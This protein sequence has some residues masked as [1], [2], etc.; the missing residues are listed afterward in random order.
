MKVICGEFIGR[1]LFS[2]K[3][4][5]LR[6]TSEKIR[7]AI[8]DI[9]LHSIGEPKI[10]GAKVLDLFCGTGA[11]GI[12]ALSRGAAHA[13]FVDI[14]SK[15]LKLV[16]K[17]LKSFGIIQRS[18]IFRMD[19]RLL[20]YPN[21]S[22]LNGMGLVFIDAPYGEKLTFPTLA[23]LS[24]SGWLASDCKVVVEVSQKENFS[25]PKDY[26]ILDNRAYGKTRILF[27]GYK[28]DRV[29]KCEA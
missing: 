25:L 20:P 10:A 11:M 29:L 6:P 3:G 14:N 5:T 24:E 8:F 17:S 21:P 22:G 26:S 9:I 27:L 19:C 15:A 23:R 7:A 12:E 18:S 28:G 13:T 2:P 4:I 16:T 1:K